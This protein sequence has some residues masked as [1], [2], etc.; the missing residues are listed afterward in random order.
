MTTEQL[1]FTSENITAL[2]V[3][4]VIFRPSSIQGTSGWKVWEPVK[5]LVI[6]PD[7]PLGRAWGDDD[8]Y[9]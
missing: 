1:Q 7:S 2:T 3:N 6:D 8:D 4:G 9:D 5:L